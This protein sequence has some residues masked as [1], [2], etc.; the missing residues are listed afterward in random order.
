MGQLSGPARWSRSKDGKA[1]PDKL[2][3]AIHDLR[4]RALRRLGTPGRPLMVAATAQF[5]SGKPAASPASPS[6]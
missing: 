4:L 1:V 2:L 3:A 6:R 5:E